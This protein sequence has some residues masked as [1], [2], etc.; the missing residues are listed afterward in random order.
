MKKIAMVITRMLPGGAS[1]IVRQ[2]IEGG[3]GKYDFTLFCGTEDLDAEQITALKSDFKTVLIPEMRRKPN[4]FLDFM[5][6]RHLLR[7]FCCNEFDVAHTHTSK[8]GVLGRLAA[9]N[10][11][12]EKIIHTPHGTIYTEDGTIPGITELSMLR[13]LFLY[14]ERYCRDRTNYL[15]VLS[16]HEYDV[17]VRLGI[18]NPENTVIVPNGIDKDFFM[19]KAEERKT[20]RNK[21]GMDDEEI[22]IASTGRIAPEKG[23]ETLIK[24]FDNI[25]SSDKRLK[26]WIV[27]DGPS[28]TLLEEKYSNLVQSGNIRFFGFQNDVK[29]FLAASD[30]FVL[31]SIYEGFGLS[32]VE[33]M[34]SGLP[35]IA[36]S[37]GGIPDIIDD[38][39]DGF[40]FPPGDD[41][42]LSQLIL[43]VYPSEAYRKSIGQRARQK[44]LNFTLDRMLSKYFQLYDVQIS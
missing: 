2:I 11:G 34:A 37:T 22:I 40:T 3:S 27:G 7:E 17:T 16:R 19:I 35:C 41:S 1:R 42:T 5:A 6:Y 30:I 4:P 8:A 9:A 29:P 25:H 18:S 14:A 13:R 12:I 43:K 36:S 15:T 32:L 44:A 23:H 39:H 21:F 10:S 33:A 31:P 28:R 20:I 24:A 26:L 38:S